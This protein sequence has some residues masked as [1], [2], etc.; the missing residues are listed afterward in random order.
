MVGYLKEDINC[1]NF[2]V[3]KGELAIMNDIYSNIEIEIVTVTI[4]LASIE[5]EHKE[6]IRLLL[7]G[8]DD[9]YANGINIRVKKDLIDFENRKE[10]TEEEFGF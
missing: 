10:Y 5:G 4:L 3:K 9:V 7:K 6:E 8:T 1:G 2:V